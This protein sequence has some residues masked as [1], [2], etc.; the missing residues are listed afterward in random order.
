KTLDE[1]IPRRGLP[2]AEVLKYGIQIADALAK[3]HSAGIVHRDLKPSNVIISDEGRAKVLD[4]GLAKLTE[5]TE[6]AELDVTR[7]VVHDDKPLTEDGVVV[8]TVNYMSPEQAEGKNIDPRS[9][10]FSFGALLYEM[11]TGRRAFQGESKLA[12]LTAILKEDPTSAAQFT[13]GLPRDLDKIINRCLRKDRERRFQG[14]ADLRVALEDLKE[15]SESGS[16]AAEQRVLPTKPRRSLLW[17][18]ALVSVAV[19]AAVFRFTRDTA[20]APEPALTVTPLTTYEGTESHPTFSPDGN[21][22]AFTWDGENEDNFDI[23]V[24]LIGTATPLRLTTDAAEDV[25]PAWSPDGRWIAFVRFRLGDSSEEVVVVPAIGG[26][27]RVLAE[28]SIARPGE[29]SASPYLD[30]TPESEHLFVGLNGNDGEPAGLFRLS[31]ET[32]E[33]RR[34]TTGPSTTTDSQPS[35]APDGRTVAF[36]RTRGIAGDHLY[37]LPLEEDFTASGEPIRLTGALGVISGSAWA[38]GG[39]HLVFAG[40]ATFQASALLRMPASGG[41][42]RQVLSE[43]SGFH[44]TPAVSATAKRL[45]FS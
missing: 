29:Y 9:D 27:E 15:E 31:V 41:E 5:S 26:P 24:T 21:Q 4:F 14:M 36:T 28:V 1:V 7:T 22:V 6:P 44:E 13:D 37:V 38:P 11:A 20:P 42:A 3:A 18:V 12:T 33:L 10:I 30:W 25:G 8:G 16:L 34:L 32:G 39:K 23:Y 2:L 43:G 40:G 35:L 45:V 19:L 17:P